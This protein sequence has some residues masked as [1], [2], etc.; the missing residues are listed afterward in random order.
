MNLV[1]PA[2]QADTFNGYT[3]SALYEYDIVNPTN[4]ETRVEFRFPLSSEAKLYQVASVQWNG[5]PVSSWRVVSGTIAWEGRM[6]PGEKNVVSVHYVTWGMD[7]FLFVVPEP[8]EVKN[9]RL[10]VALDAEEC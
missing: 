3:L 2:R 1:D 4:T 5:E 7:G 9:F 8:R 6:G 10:T